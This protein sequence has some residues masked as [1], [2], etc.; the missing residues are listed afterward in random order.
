[1]KLT[2]CENGH[3]YDADKFSSCPHCSQGGE[4]GTVPFA[5]NGGGGE[6]PFHNPGFDGSDAVTGAFVPGA[7]QS[8]PVSFSAGDDN[9]TVAAPQNLKMEEAADEGKT[10]AF[11]NWTAAKNA[12]DMQQSPVFKSEGQI[13]RETV[14]PV[15]GW[16]VCIEG[17]NY[18]KSFN[19]YS[20]KN[21]IGRDPGM[22]V[23]LPG[24]T[25]ISRIKHAVIV[26]EPKKR[27]FFTYPG[28]SHELFYC[29]DKVV[30]TSMWLSDR[31]VITIGQT[32][33]V[34]VPFCD[35]SFGWGTEEKLPKE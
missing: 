22:D 28:E 31:D 16:L 35:V 24:D 34:F 23:C 33:L 14:N 5:F 7:V 32:R 2:K 21:F 30:L 1:M 19:L 26:Y 29:N 3:Y 13:L 18:G 6:S 25:S 9:V 27:Q 4:A 12:G 8:T 11:F 10:Q 17:S 15:V 20:G